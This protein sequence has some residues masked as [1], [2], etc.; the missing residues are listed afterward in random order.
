MVGPGE[1]IADIRV[2]PAEPGEW[3]AMWVDPAHRGAGL[4]ALAREASARPR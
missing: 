2:R 3:G 1:D 4:V